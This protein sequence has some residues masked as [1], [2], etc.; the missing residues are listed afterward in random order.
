MYMWKD[1]IGW[2]IYMKKCPLEQISFD[3]YALEQM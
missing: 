2:N 1:M 3:K